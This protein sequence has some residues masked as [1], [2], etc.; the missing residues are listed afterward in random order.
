MHV[1]E[2]ENLKNSYDC[3]VKIAGF[4]SKLG[5]HIYVF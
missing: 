2:I 1:S 3:A 5:I 4:T